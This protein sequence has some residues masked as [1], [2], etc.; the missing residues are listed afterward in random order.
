ME[1]LSNKAS[2]L[3][4]S[5]GSIFSSQEVPITELVWNW[6]VTFGV[7]LKGKSAVE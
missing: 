2:F 7:L 1:L 3:G 5:D 6:A 4:S